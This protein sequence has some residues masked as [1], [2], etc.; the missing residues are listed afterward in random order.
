MISVITIRSEGE[1]I[2]EEICQNQCLG[3]RWQWPGPGWRPW[4]WKISGQVIIDL[5]I[6]FTGCSHGLG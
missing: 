3:E 1:E 6:E 4:K 2:A 5:K